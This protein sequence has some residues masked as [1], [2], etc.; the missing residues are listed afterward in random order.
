MTR[1]GTALE[2]TVNPAYLPANTDSGYR[3]TARQEGR[4]LHITAECVVASDAGH[5]SP[6][7]DRYM[8]APRVYQGQHV[9]TLAEL[10]ADACGWARI[11]PPAWAEMVPGASERLAL[12]WLGKHRQR[13]LEIYGNKLLEEL[14]AVGAWTTT[15][16]DGATEYAAVQIP[17]SAVTEIL[18]HEHAGDPDDD[19]KLARI[20]PE[21]GAPKWVQDAAGWVDEYGWGLIG[22]KRTED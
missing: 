11:D 18:G 22:P 21:T 8:V 4:H 2:V 1:E 10:I 7:Y 20:L 5:V 14:P 6:H 9:P 3:I 13:V 19:A 12:E 15:Y 17:W 16:S